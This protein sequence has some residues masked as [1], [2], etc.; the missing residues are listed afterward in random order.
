MVVS[1]PCPCPTLIQPSGQVACVSGVPHPWMHGR[2]SSRHIP[3]PSWDENLMARALERPEEGATCQ[4]KRWGPS[5]GHRAV[6]GDTH[7]D[8]SVSA[9]RQGVCRTRVD[10]TFQGNCSLV[11]QL[12]GPLTTYHR[13]ALASQ[14]APPSLLPCGSH[15]PLVMG[16]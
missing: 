2:E 14:M 3:S 8:Q 9:E 7:T 15:S 1:C 5:P 12:M 16:R 4:M 10:E 13:T 6:S 11:P